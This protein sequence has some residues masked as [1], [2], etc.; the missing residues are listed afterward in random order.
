MFVRH[1][2]PM[3]MSSEAEAQQLFRTRDRCHGFPLGYSQACEW[4]NTFRGSK[5]AAQVFH[6]FKMQGLSH[7]IVYDIM[8][9]MC[10]HKDKLLDMAIRAQGFVPSG[11]DGFDPPFCA[12][13]DIPATNC[14]LCDICEHSARESSAQ[15]Q[16]QS[17][18]V[19]NLIAIAPANQSGFCNKAAPFVLL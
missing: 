12:R 4:R 3:T 5:L 13:L 8:K 11:Y 14:P 2:T 9:L 18:L 1:T 10:L 17:R 19:R 15:A 16:V 6:F 7:D